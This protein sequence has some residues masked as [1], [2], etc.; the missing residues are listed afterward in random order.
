MH[1]LQCRLAGMDLQQQAADFKS[2]QLKTTERRLEAAPRSALRLDTG[3]IFQS[4][5]P[6][7][8]EMLCS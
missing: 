4:P 5:S 2:V 6:G 1:L 8:T 3:G 7:C